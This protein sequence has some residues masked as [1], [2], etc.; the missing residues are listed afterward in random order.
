MRILFLAGPPSGPALFDAVITRLGQGQALDL[1]GDGA[2]DWKSCAEA[3]APKLD[4]DTLLVAHGLS[5]PTAIA[6]A[7]RRAPAGLLLSNGPITRLDPITMAL[8][9]LAGL[10][11]GGALVEN[12][13]LY[14]KLWTSYLASSAGLRRTVVNPYVMDRDTVAALCTPLVAQRAGRR[15]L[16]RYLASLGQG[17]PELR[18]LGCPTWLVWG[19][20]DWLYPTSEADYADTILGGGRRLDI[21]GARF[22]HPVERPWAFADQVATVHQ[23][24]Q[25]AGAH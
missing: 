17:L 25:G 19:D 21:P 1:F 3:I 13:V 5:V 20:A 23:M 18:S 14:P 12:L 4:A 16:A 2:T 8:S 11:G 15:A 7:T 6:A 22:Y 24:L 9:R 10:P